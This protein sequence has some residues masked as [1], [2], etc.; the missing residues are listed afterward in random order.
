MALIGLR[1]FVTCDGCGTKMTFDIDPA[2]E[3]PQDWSWHDLVVDTVRGYGP[4]EGGFSSVQGESDKCLCPA[5]TK[6]VDA[7]VPEDRNATDDEITEALE[8]ELYPNG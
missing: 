7:S 3:R 8:R 1:A 6:T 5:C 2:E 4:R